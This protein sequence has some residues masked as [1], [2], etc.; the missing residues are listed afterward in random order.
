[1]GSRSACGGTNDY[2]G[3]RLPVM[4]V[5]RVVGQG[6]D[7]PGLRPPVA[8]KPLF[9]FARQSKSLLLCSRSFVK[10]GRRGMRSSSLVLFLRHGRRL[11]CGGTFPLP[12]EG[13]PAGRGRRVKRKQGGATPTRVP[14]GR[15]RRVKRKRGGAMPAPGARAA[16]L[17]Q[18][19]TALRCVTLVRG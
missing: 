8:G 5:L 3:L 9:L 15:G 4:V 11:P 10:S 19:H 2:P 16:C 18:P 12:L 13:V 17:P 1:M 7:Y 14:A 6:H